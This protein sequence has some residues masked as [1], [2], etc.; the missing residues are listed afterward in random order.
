M[1]RDRPENGSVIHSSPW[2][3]PLGFGRCTAIPRRLAQGPSQWMKRGRPRP[4]ILEMWP[5][6][7]PLHRRPGGGGGRLRLTTNFHTISA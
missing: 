4:R 7:H 2:A 1:Q 5:P 3:S 6:W